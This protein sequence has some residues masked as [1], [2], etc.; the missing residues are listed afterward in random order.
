[1]YTTNKSCLM[2]CMCTATADAADSTII[3]ICSTITPTCCHLSFK[4][5]ILLTKYNENAQTG[6]T[7]KL[8]HHWHSSNSNDTQTPKVKPFLTEWLHC[9]SLKQ[10]CRRDCFARWP[11][12]QYLQVK[13]GHW[14]SWMELHS[15]CCLGQTPEREERKTSTP[16]LLVVVELMLNVLRCH[17]TY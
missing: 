11:C 5:A 8:K 9:F 14:T 17:L 6:T 3:Y 1:M 7:C 16:L 4:G 10:E 13:T 12:S 2:A 15:V